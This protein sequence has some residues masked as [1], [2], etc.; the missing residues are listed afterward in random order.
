MKD[1]KHDTGHDRSDRFEHRRADLNDEHL[2]VQR[3]ENEGGRWWRGAPPVSTSPFAGDRAATQVRSVRSVGLLDD[4]VRREA[5]AEA[6][7]NGLIPAR[8]AISP[9]LEQGPNAWEHV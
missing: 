1:T 4:A 8:V 6:E 7:A 2:A 5:E 9:S 3:W